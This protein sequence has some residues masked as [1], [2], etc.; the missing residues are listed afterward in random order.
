MCGKR[1]ILKRILFLLFLLG[2]WASIDLGY[3][4]FYSLIPE[5]NDGITICGFWANLFLPDYGWSRV[6]YLKL[7]RNAVSATAIV[8]VLLFAVTFCKQTNN[9]SEK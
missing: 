4:F 7:F 8:G 9:S 6:G 1:E 3:N 5:A 2:L